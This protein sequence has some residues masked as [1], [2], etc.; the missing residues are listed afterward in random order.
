MTELERVKKELS[1]TKAILGDLLQERGINAARVISAIEQGATPDNLQTLAVLQGDNEDEKRELAEAILY[2]IYRGW[3]ES[4]CDNLIDAIF[5]G[6]VT[7]EDELRQRL[8]ENTDGA[9]I[10]THDQYMVIFAAESRSVS[11][12][13]EG[14]RELGDAQAPPDE[15]I[16]LWAVLTYREDVNDRLGRMGL[17]DGDFDRQTWLEAASEGE[18]ADWDETLAHRA[19]QVLAGRNR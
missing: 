2:R 4:E 13:A 8:D 10:Y 12:G 9:L 18:Y 7:D 16:G 5:N 14:V 11:A 6:E 15:Q 3:V 17:G 19:A 1:D